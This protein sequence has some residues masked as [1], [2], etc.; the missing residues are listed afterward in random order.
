VF[1]IPGKGDPGSLKAKLACRAVRRKRLALLLSLT[2]R[3]RL[4][5][6]ACCKPPNREGFAWLTRFRQ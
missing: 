2:N 1:L 3:T 5:V 4:L 6:E